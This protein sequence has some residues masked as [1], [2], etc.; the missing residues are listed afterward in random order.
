MR[1]FQWLVS[2]RRMAQGSFWSSVGRG[3][4]KG[5]NSIGGRPGDVRMAE[6]AA[7][8]GSNGCQG[9]FEW[10]RGG[11]GQGMFEW[12]SGRPGEVR[13]AGRAGGLGRF[14][15]LVWGVARRVACFGVS[16][17]QRPGEVRFG[18][19]GGAA[20]GCS[21]RWKGGHRRL[22]LMGGL[23]RDARFGPEEAAV[24]SF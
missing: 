16:V 15:G 5:I 14:E 17:V 9:M 20:V 11:G 24:G 22:V 12:L 1:G 10:L 4:F 21:F 19:W 2:M 8:G 13:M 23:P 7:G 3:M 6:R 18:L